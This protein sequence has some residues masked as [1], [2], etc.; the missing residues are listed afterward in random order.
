MFTK[1]NR[2]SSVSIYNFLL[3]HELT[4]YSLQTNHNDATFAY[5][6]P[7]FLMIQLHLATLL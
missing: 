7:S 2:S 5:A 1:Q 3:G 6:V 4:F